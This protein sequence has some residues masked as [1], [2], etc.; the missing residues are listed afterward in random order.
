[1]ASELDEFLMSNYGVGLAQLG[2]LKPFVL[3]SMVLI[4]ALPCT[5]TE[6]YETFYTSK[7][8]DAGKTVVGLETVE[9]Q[10]GIF[11]Q[12]PQDLQ[13]LE[14]GKMLAEDYFQTEFQSMMEAYLAED[15]RKLDSVM[16]SSGMMAEYR[17]F[18]WMSEINLGFR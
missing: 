5:E 2:V 15:I 9:F 13:L 6:S 18:Y 8:T 12:I 3:S 17:A 11:D 16:T 4:K 10:V 7:A 14:L 1:M